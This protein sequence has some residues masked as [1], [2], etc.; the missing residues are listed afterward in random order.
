MLIRNA[1]WVLF[2]QVIRMAS[3]DLNHGVTKQKIVY[4]A[5]LLIGIAILKGIFLFLTRWIIIGISREIEYDLRNDLFRHLEKQSASY[6]QNTA[7][8]TSWPA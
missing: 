1:I 4:F 2:P 6:Y 5:S 3:D 7:P 8:A